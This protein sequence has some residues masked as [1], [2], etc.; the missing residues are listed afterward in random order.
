VFQVV[1]LY[2]HQGLKDQN[3]VNITRTIGFL[4]LKFAKNSNY[5]QQLNYKIKHLIS[6]TITNQIISERSLNQNIERK[7]NPIA[8]CQ[9]LLK[10][11]QQIIKI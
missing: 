3:V 1:S 4:V 9:T 7:L 5:N 10:K 2:T 11:I 6:I 8:L